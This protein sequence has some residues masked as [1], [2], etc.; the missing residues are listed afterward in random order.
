MLNIDL[1]PLFRSTIGFDQMVSFLEAATNT[2]PET[3]SYPPYDIEKR[4]EDD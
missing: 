3:L 1:S 2:D 4:G